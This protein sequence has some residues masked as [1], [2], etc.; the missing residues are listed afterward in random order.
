MKMKLPPFEVW[1]FAIILAL[2]VIFCGCATETRNLD[3]GG[4]EIVKAWGV[5]NG[6]TPKAYVP[7]G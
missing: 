3:L 7:E 2:S 5:S 1:Y 4:H 6:A